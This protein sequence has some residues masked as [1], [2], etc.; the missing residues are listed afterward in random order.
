M[1]PKSYF[2]NERTF[3][4]WVSAA[5]LLVTIAVL[6]LDF[7]DHGSHAARIGLI[8]CGSAIVMVTYGMFV[9]S[10]RIGLL[11]SGQAYGYVDWVGPLMLGASVLVGIIVLFVFLILEGTGSHTTQ[12]D[13][14]DANSDQRL[15]SRCAVPSSHFGSFFAGV[16]A[17]RYLRRQEEGLARDPIADAHHCHSDQV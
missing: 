1:E 3:I 12:K 16:R 6:I 2:A 5:L 13:R 10:R 9:Y 7:S 17:Q 15:E 4:Q 14:D 11:A 8:L